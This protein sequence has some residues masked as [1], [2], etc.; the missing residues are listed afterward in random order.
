MLVLILK[1]ILGRTL[2]SHVVVS[3]IT[4]SCCG[5]KVMWPLPQR[6][7]GM[8]LLL[9]NCGPPPQHAHC[10]NH[11]EEVCQEIDKAITRNIQN[12]LNTLENDVA[13]ITSE[14]QKRLQQDR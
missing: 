13:V 11:L 7:G 6:K 2:I 5:S 4:F 10:E 3:V 12:T 9:V 1:G 14:M 8:W